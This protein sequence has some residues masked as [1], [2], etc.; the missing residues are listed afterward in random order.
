MTTTQTLPATPTGWLLGTDCGYRHHGGFVKDCTSPAMHWS[1]TPTSNG[2]W[3]LALIEN[4]VAISSRRFST[5][6]DA[7]AYVG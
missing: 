3:T 1:L 2:E 4:R 5:I 7:I 6:E